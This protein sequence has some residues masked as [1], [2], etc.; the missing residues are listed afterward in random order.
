VENL[1]PD[2]ALAPSLRLHRTQVRT[3]LFRIP[4][5][6]VAGGLRRPLTRALVLV[7][8][9]YSTYPRSC[10]T[11]NSDPLHQTPSRPTGRI[12][13]PRLT[14]T[15]A[16][17][18]RIFTWSVSTPISSYVQ[19]PA[20]ASSSTRRPSALLETPTLSGLQLSGTWG[21]TTPVPSTSRTFIQS[22]QMS[23][24]AP[25]S[26]ANS[27]HLSVDLLRPESPFSAPASV[28]NYHEPS[29]PVSLTPVSPFE[30]FDDLSLPDSPA[31]P[32][33][34]APPPSPHLVP[35]NHSSSG[36]IPSL[37][38]SPGATDAFQ[39]A[40][41]LSLP[42]LQ[43]EAQEVSDPPEVFGQLAAGSSDNTHPNTQPANPAFAS[44]AT[45]VPQSIQHVPANFQNRPTWP[46]LGLY[47]VAEYQRSISTRKARQKPEAAPMKIGER[48]G[49]IDAA[50]Q[51][52]LQ[53]MYL[54]IMKETIG[55]SPWG[56]SRDHMIEAGM[57]I[58]DKGTG[59]KGD[60]FMTDKL[61]ETVRFSHSFVSSI[62]IRTL[63]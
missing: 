63:G 6:T 27:P 12:S 52:Y 36:I 11:F 2:L 48:I 41:R 47:E 51:G 35:I 26:Y 14:I 15:R 59:M 34:P 46:E 56:L 45:T 50:I 30:M 7:S 33:T 53:V 29:T 44:P 10:L 22:T 8:N 20:Q 61:K 17:S 18:P 40:A 31:I 57:R 1:H 60:G 43:V 21:Q 9:V 25:G 49:T 54:G 16:G 39:L 5:F 58:A 28:L 23:A 62:L 32:A 24:S 38:D 13:T 3:Q 4:P 55:R 19:R 42:A 37:G